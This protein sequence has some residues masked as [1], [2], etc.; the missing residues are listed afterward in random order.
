[1]ANGAQKAKVNTLQ[2]TLKE[3]KSRQRRQR[4]NEANFQFIE[5]KVKAERVSCRG[6]KEGSERAARKG[7]GKHPSHV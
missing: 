1:M 6:N 3:K 2:D 7:I 5:S 4:E